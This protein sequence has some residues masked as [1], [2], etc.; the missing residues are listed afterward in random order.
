MEGHYIATHVGLLPHKGMEYMYV[1]LNPAWS[2]V[3]WWCIPSVIYYVNSVVTIS[4]CAGVLV[5]TID[6]GGASPVTGL[7]E[8]GV[9]LHF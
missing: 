2:P 7:L 6:T 1:M 5:R 9:K 3:I 8:A 4:L